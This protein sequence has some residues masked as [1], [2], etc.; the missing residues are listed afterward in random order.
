MAAGGRH[1]RGGQQTVGF[2]VR[3]GGMPTSLH[4]REMFT[5]RVEFALA[6]QCLD[7]VDAEVVGAAVCSVGES[8]TAPRRRSVA[9]SKSPLPSAAM[10]LMPAANA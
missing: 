8:G 1:P 9:I 6:G 2:A 3:V 7:V 4:L 5:R 10:P